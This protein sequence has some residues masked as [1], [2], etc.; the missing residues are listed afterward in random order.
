MYGKMGYRDFG[1][2]REFSCAAG[3]PV[4]L[5]EVP[6]GEYALLRRACLPADGVIQEGENLS[7]LAATA[8]LY[9]GADFLLAAN[10][11]GETLTCMELLGREDAASGIV[12]ALGCEN[13]AFRRGARAMMRPLK[14]DAPL[15]GY[16]GLVFD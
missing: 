15:P 5:R 12:A 4:S 9:A 7:F 13:G 11:E 14:P 6:A 2:A 16:L 3:E 10:V 1:V 8:K